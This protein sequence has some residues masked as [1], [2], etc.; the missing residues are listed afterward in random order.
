M[1]GS[2]LSL[3]AAV[4]LMDK[5]RVLFVCTHNSARS[6]MAE[7]F[8]NGLGEG[9][10][11]AES[12]GLE[13]RN[14]NPLVVKVMKEAGY[15]LTLNKADSVFDFYKEGR[16]YDHVIYVCDKA[17][18]EKCPIFPGLVRSLNW[19]FKDPAE[20]SGTEQEKLDSI[21]KIRD[22][23]RDRI[24]HWIAELPNA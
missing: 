10:F 23:I 16:L 19:P 20:V 2:L 22:E 12:A 5:I 7:T 6:Q 17:T 24:E 21:R 9:R 18:E 8:L 13:P 15:D 14:I 1:E 4:V 11:E 3:I